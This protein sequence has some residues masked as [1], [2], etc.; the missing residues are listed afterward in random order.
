MTDKV[1]EKLLNQE[2]VNK[3]IDEAVAEEIA[4]SKKEK[5][6]KVFKDIKKVPHKSVLWGNKTVFYVF[7]REQGTEQQVTGA[8]ARSLFGSN[9]S[10]IKS[11]E[12]GEKSQATTEKYV[13]KFVEYKV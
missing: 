3:S 1:L 13:I 6:A 4:N 7:N 9:I 8:Q 5:V 2:S 10:A 12:R 11:L